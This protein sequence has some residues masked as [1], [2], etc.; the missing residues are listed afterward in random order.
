MEC[1]K[2]N[3]K[4][5]NYVEIMFFMIWVQHSSDEDRLPCDDN[6]TK[7]KSLLKSAVDNDSYPCSGNHSE[8]FFEKDR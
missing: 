3:L 5:Y 2:F 8:L 6:R 7:R 4:I 1:N